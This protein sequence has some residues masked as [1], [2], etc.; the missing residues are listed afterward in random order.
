MS[1]KRVRKIITVSLSRNNPLR[2]D[3]RIIWVR[4][5]PPKI[6]IEIILFFTAS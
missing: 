1:I 4:I 5:Y 2:E 3:P 6:E